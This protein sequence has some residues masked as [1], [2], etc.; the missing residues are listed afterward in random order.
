MLLWLPNAMVSTSTPELDVGFRATFAL[1][2]ILALINLVGKAVL[3]ISLFKMVPWSRKV[4][5]I[6]LVVLFI[7]GFG[8]KALVMK[9]FIS[10]VEQHQVQMAKNRQHALD[11]INNAKGRRINNF[12]FYGVIVSLL[13]AL[14]RRP[15]H[16]VS[17]D[18]SV[19]TFNSHIVSPCILAIHMIQ[20]TI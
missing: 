7:I 5:I 16:G 6:G 8:I 12:T 2:L 10:A 15:L 19:F 18:D 9:S 17:S 3:S 14:I 4:A 13:P 1:G 11:A 20:L